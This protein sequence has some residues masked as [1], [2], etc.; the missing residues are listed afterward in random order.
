LGDKSMM[1]S[2]ILDKSREYI[3]E[4]KFE[5]AQIILRR[6][7][8]ENPKNATALDLLGDLA[9]KMGRT[10]EAIQRYDQASNVFTNISQYSEAIISLEKIALIDRKNEDVVSR[11][12]DIYRFYGLPNKAIS[13][14]LNLCSWALENKEDGI[15]VSGLRKIAEAQSK[16]LPLRLSFAKILLAIGRQQEAQDELKKLKTLA[17]D[18]NDTAILS[19]V[20]RLLPQTDGGEELDPKSRIELG[21]LLY[22]IGSKDEA[23]VEF[24]KAV[25]DLLQTGDKDEATKVLNRIVEIDPNNE[26]ALDKLKEL[27]GE[28]GIAETAEEAVERT[29][30][31]APTEEEMILAE[32]PSEET[33][34]PPT[35]EKPEEPT[36][37]EV[38]EIQA[39]EPIL[40][41]TTEPIQVGP[42]PEAE[43]TEPAAREPSPEEAI[44]MFEDLGKEIDGFVAASDEEHTHGEDTAVHE[45]STTDTSHLEGQIAD[46]EFLL[47]QA[48]APPEPSFEVMKEF[49]DFK[50]SIIW[51]DEDPRKK[52]DIAKMAF[53]AGLYESALDYVVDIKNRKETWPASLELHG[54][55]LVKLGRYNEAMRTIA[56]SLLLEE[57]GEGEKIELRYL[58]ASAYEGLG[59]F[60]NALRE[61]ERILKINPDYKDVK[62]MYALLG[63]KELI[64]EELRGP[65]EAP[66]IREQEVV[67][68][69]PM[70]GPPPARHGPEKVI[71]T[72]IPGQGPISEE[73]FPTVVQE[74][75][76]QETRPVERPHRDEGVQEEK[77]EKKSSEIEERPGE[78]IA[79]L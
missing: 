58:L 38:Y 5:K 13:T 6:A 9:L 15:F 8:S 33:I 1:E 50:N 67:R 78:N 43:P 19:E 59:D 16:N 31:P 51:Q 39:E 24:E 2:E 73:P 22:E 4:G 36:A 53:N 62:E 35:E 3:Q 75:P 69:Q 45:G 76:G 68:K 7:L 18:T 65:V 55:S 47:K 60:D 49:D 27:S 63:G 66:K 54:G 10:K 52:L 28:A 21:N 41:P 12:S 20:D 77:A 57:I 23:I 56:Q 26:K 11:L 72:Y 42:P 25:S 40:G 46:I 44:K 17:L 29:T 71:P 61:T 30:E 64:T 74:M 48:E 79:F 32:A 70:E 34:T 37:E 14:I